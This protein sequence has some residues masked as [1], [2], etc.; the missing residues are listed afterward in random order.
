ME[1]RVPSASPPLAIPVT[2]AGANGVADPFWWEALT[3]PTGDL[4]AVSVLFSSGNTVPAPML[5][6]RFQ[7]H[8]WHLGRAGE[9]TLPVRLVAAD[10]GTADVT[11]AAFRKRPPRVTLSIVSTAQRDV[12][13]SNIVVRP[14]NAP[15]SLVDPPPI[16]AIVAPGQCLLIPVRVQAASLR[17]PGTPVGPVR[18]WC[19]VELEITSFYAGVP[20]VWNVIRSVIGTEMNFTVVRTKKSHTPISA[21]AVPFFPTL[22]AGCFDRA[23]EP[24]LPRIMDEDAADN[25]MPDGFRRV[26]YKVGR[27]VFHCPTDVEMSKSENVA[28]PMTSSS[29]LKHT[30]QALDAQDVLGQSL[31][32]YKRRMQR[33][34]RLETK[35]LFQEM[36]RFDICGAYLVPE[37]K[38]PL[39]VK[40]TVQ[41]LAESCPALAL[42]D[43]VRLR[44]VQPD[45]LQSVEL[46]ARVIA[47]DAIKS[48]IT[49]KLPAKYVHHQRI[50]D[51]LANLN[52]KSAQFHVRFCTGHH[53]EAIQKLSSAV[54]GLTKSTYQRLEYCPKLRAV[55]AAG[56]GLKASNELMSNPV[57][58]TY[59]DRLNTRQLEAVYMCINTLKPLHAEDATPNPA[60]TSPWQQE[61]SPALCIFGPPGTGKTLT[62]TAAITAIL[63]QSPSERI[64]ATA[65]SQQAADV[66]CERLIEYFNVGRNDM[67]RLN[68]FERPVNQ[69]RTRTLSHVLIDKNGFFDLPS[70]A[71]LASYRVIVCSCTSVTLIDLPRNHFGIVFV[72]E[73]A[74]A[75]EA[76]TLVPIVKFA[77]KGAPI[78]LCGD[79][80]QLNADVRS[81]RAAKL[82]LGI[83]LMERIMRSRRND[84]NTSQ[85]I[86]LQINY[87]VN[88]PALLELPARLFYNSDL[89][90]R[91]GLPKSYRLVEDLT[92]LLPSPVP[93]LFMGL[94]SREEFVSERSPGLRNM[95][96]ALKIAEICKRLVKSKHC[97]ADDIGVIAPYRAQVQAVRQLL[98]KERLD[99]VKVGTVGDY[100]GQEGQV[101][102]IST[103]LSSNRSFNA[104]K[105]LGQ[106]FVGNSAK[107]FNVS[108]TRAES[109][110]IV[111]GNPFILLLDRYW[112]E[113]IHYSVRLGCYAGVTFPGMEQ[114]SINKCL[115]SSLKTPQI[116]GLGSGEAAS[117]DHYAPGDTSLMYEQWHDLSAHYQDEEDRDWRVRL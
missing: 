66:I 75:L 109:L 92:D 33:A 15:F 46:I 8:D 112:A 52:N 57:L 83:S 26:Q 22:F 96:E 51:L 20:V 110:L 76:E 16:G 77:S 108:I 24:T 31:M 50:A 10:F 115:D 63:L 93:L 100:Q 56:R 53:F 82:G 49:L 17:R 68:P 9:P 1:G 74:Q 95:D 97:R 69:A 73:A 32:G 111:V 116:L 106:G 23:H 25:L 84:G 55:E 102:I 89:S 88:H 58:V 72:D 28:S 40:I 61:D 80:Y 19:L 42:F 14:E 104:E 105:S 98:R 34:L 94:A 67:F 43:P 81:E 45:L 37:K 18:A 103:S 7:H 5:G 99:S 62:L 29:T 86:Q 71:Q 41:G 78:V 79:P 117:M 60:Q 44:P 47:V 2:A 38:H 114:I 27:P 21:D 70:Q 54:E 107:K 13:I 12:R 48:C 59:L 36:D 65:P 30:V 35:S 4:S 6:V 64:L 113:L 90:V 39:H 3:G 11:S 101:I 87:R 85:I 91:P